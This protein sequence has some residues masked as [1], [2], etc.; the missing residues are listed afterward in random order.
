M[1]RGFP[2]SIVYAQTAHHHEKKCDK[3]ESDKIGKKSREILLL[4]DSSI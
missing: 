1:L 2:A 3:K 4:F